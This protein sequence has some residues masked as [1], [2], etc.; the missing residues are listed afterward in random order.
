M[1]VPPDPKSVVAQNDKLLSTRRIGICDL[2]LVVV[3]DPA[4]ALFHPIRRF[5][6]VAPDQADIP[7]KPLPDCSRFVERAEEQ[8]AQVVDRIAW[9]NTR[10]PTSNERLVHLLCGVERALAVGADIIVPEVVIGGEPQARRRWGKRFGH[11]ALYILFPPP[12]NHSTTVIQ[13]GSGGTIAASALQRDHG[14]EDA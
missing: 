2:Q 3:L 12:L 10:V 1:C 9:R 11:T 5:I 4:E 14:D 6:V 13:V 8:V 7:V